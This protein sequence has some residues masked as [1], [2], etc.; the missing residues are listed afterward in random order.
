MFEEV[1]KK[2][3]KSRLADSLKK[4]V[5]GLVLLVPIILFLKNYN[6]MT[7][8]SRDNVGYGTRAIISFTVTS[9]DYFAYR[10]DNIY[11]GNIS[12]GEVLGNVYYAGLASKEGSKYRI[13]F[14]VEVAAT[15][16]L[17]I[18]LIKK[19]AEA[20]KKITCYGYFSTDNGVKT[21]MSD[22]LVEAGYS[23]SEIGE[24]T[25]NHI[26]SVEGILPFYRILF[27]A[28]GVFLI[29][30]GLIQFIVALSGEYSNDF[31]EDVREAN[32]SEEEIEGEYCRAES[33]AADNGIMFGDRLTF[34]DVY[35]KKPR[36]LENDKILEIRTRRRLLFPGNY[37]QNVKIDISYYAEGIKEPCRLKVLSSW[38][39]IDSLR[40]AYAAAYP[41]VEYTCS[42]SRK[43]YRG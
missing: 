14:P 38:S 13:M 32:L 27:A 9:P 36:V 30:F 23:S 37:T 1:R 17:M 19:A 26:F 25:L 10:N 16:K 21:M 12:V 39:S 29:M 24:F 6:P 20:G 28:V 15:Q 42:K 41:K 34:L 7:E 2:T 22:M 8:L 43:K 4:I 11:Y 33:F 35:G 40:E 18:R 3:I 5:W 31:F